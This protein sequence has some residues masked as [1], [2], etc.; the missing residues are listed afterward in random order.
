[1]KT[2]EI[3]QGDI[4]FVS[5]SGTIA[6]IIQWITRSKFYHCAVFIDD[7]INLV[8]ANGGEKTSKVPLSNYLNSNNKLYVYR[9]TSLSDLER[10]KVVNYALNHL[11]MEYDYMA[12]LAELAR[13]E[14]GLSLKYYDE[15]NKRICSSFVNDCFLNIGKKLTIQPVPS[16]QDLVNGKLLTLIGKLENK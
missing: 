8:E 3:K 9:L 2:S 16:P 11:G 7:G 1:M 4:L 10:Y 15:G 12:I 5:G 6:S 13:Y 14:L